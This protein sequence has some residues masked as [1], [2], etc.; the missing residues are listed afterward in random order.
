MQQD[1]GVTNQ[2]AETAQLRCST[3]VKVRKCVK[4]PG[5]FHWLHMFSEKIALKVM[6][7]ASF[8]QAIFF[9]LSGAGSWG[10]QSELSLTFSG[11]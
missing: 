8:H 7:H 9:M 6:S 1:K 4:P 10:Q 5:L 11:R 3:V 2:S